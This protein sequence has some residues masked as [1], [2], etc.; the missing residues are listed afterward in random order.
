M[1]R[2][3]AR[4]TARGGPHRTDGPMT[5]LRTIRCLALRMLCLAVLCLAATPPAS[6]GTLERVRAAG[7]L[8]CGVTAAGL[9]LSAL[10]EAGVWRGFF[11]D[12]CRA[13]AI[14]T[15][16]RDDPVVFVEVGAE[17]RFSVL[18]DRLVDVVMDAATWT[19]EREH[20]Q[21]VAFP[22][23]YL[24]DTQ[25]VMVHRALGIAALPQATGGSVCVVDGTMAA[26]GIDG[27]IARSGTRLMVKRFRST[28]GA[29]GA[30]FNHHC[31]LYTGHRLALHGQRA[32]SA[33]S[34]QDY[35]ILPD[36]ITRTPLS[37]MVRND[38]RAWEAIIRWTVLALLAAEEKGVTSANAAA[39]KSTGDAETR[40]LLGGVPGFGQDLG[41]DDGWALRVIGWVGHYGELYDRHLGRRSDLGIERGANALWN[42]GGLHQAPPLGG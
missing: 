15:L 3:P 23:V 14:A 6:A 1:D 27:W 40:R 10:D 12:L 36:A 21:D 18:R 4:K 20:S 31:D 41:L 25:A 37:P 33:P 42:A 8:R 38:D 28:E 19:Q 29:L 2:C 5:I 17:N 32:Q 26:S 11:P 24:F 35:T 9:G 30:F 13:V 39:R 22:V 16:G 7:I 34:P